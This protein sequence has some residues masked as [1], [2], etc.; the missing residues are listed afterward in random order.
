[1]RF[2]HSL[3]TLSASISGA[4]LLASNFRRFTGILVLFCSFA[5]VAAFG[6]TYY[7][8]P[9]GNGG[10]DSHNGLSWGSPW[11]SPKHNLNCGDVIIAE[12]S[13]SYDSNNFNSGHWGNVNCPSW[14]NVAWL[15]CNTFDACK[16][17][18]HNEGINVDHSFWGVQGWEVNVS[19][20]TNGF[21]FG[22]APSHANWVNIHHVIFANNI[23]NGCQAGGFVTYSLGN[24]GVDYVSIIGNIAY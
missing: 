19:D 14:N 9:A 5:P 15:K 17:W 8:A 21:C 22:V 20:G 11:L 3:L 4:K 23:A 12:P 18:S 10:S 2:L 16:I 6:T 1:M 24:S 13:T 7:L